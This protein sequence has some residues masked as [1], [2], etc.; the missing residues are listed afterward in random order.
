MFDH[1]I[2]RERPL[3]TAYRLLTSRVR[4]HIR[5]MHRAVIPY[6]GGRSRIEVDVRTPFG[7][8]VYRYGHPDPDIGLVRRLLAPGDIF[9]DG[10]SHI[11]FYALVAAAKVGAQGRVIAFEPAERTRLN[12]L[13]NVALSK[14]DWVEV[15]PNAL[16]DQVQTRT[17]YTFGEEAWGS[18]S[19]APP[20]TVDGRRAEQVETTTLDQALT[21]TD[22]SR[23]RLL[24]LDVEGAELAALRGAT[25]LLSEAHPD[26]LF[27]A[28]PDHLDRQGASLEAILTLLG[29][30][31]YVFFR[32]V[33]EKG[34]AVL[35]SDP[36]PGRD[37][38]SV[39]LFA[40]TDTDRLRRNGIAIRN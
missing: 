28:E 10:G 32:P 14:F 26:L 9:V 24:K 18:S 1:P 25:R 38:A 11:G 16:S 27:E 35:V 12:L 31:G 34:E 6:D 7:Y 30:F 40:T 5:G 22:L 37:H 17:F 2:W 19:F 23:V 8:A 3:A 20:D 29:P 13:R 36:H 15:R 33:E 39:N 4:R 21:G